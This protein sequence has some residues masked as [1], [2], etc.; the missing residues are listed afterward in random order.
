MSED[1]RTT[2]ALNDYSIEN[3][4]KSFLKYFKNIRKVGEFS[5][6]GFQS[7]RIMFVCKR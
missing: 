3:L 4:E 5:A 1:W 6:L 7:K 2:D